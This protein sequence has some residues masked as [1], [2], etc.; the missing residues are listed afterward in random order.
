MINAEKEQRSGQKWPTARDKTST[1]SHIHKQYHFFVQILCGGKSGQQGAG[2]SIVHSK[3]AEKLAKDGKNIG[4][5]YYSISSKEH[6]RPKRN[7]L[8][9][10]TGLKIIQL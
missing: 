1:P 8:I 5:H 3:M 6:K 2:E 9:L 4:Q 10:H 7:A